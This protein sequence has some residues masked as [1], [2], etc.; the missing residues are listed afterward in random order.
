[1]T[2]SR[3]KP[4]VALLI[5]PLSFGRLLYRRNYTETLTRALGGGDV[6]AWTLQIVVSLIAAG[7]ITVLWRSRD[8]IKAAA[9][10]AGTL[11]ATPHLFAYDL[12]VLAVPLAFMFQLGRSRGF[13]QHELAGM[14]LACLL[15]LILPFVKAPVGFAAVF[16]VTALII[17]R[18]L[19]A[20]TVAISR[21]EYAS[22]GR[23]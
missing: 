8:E 16:V 3:S 9:I 4:R 17:R 19:E 11:L 15:I 5:F 12:V 1:M 22:I 6:L 23:E 10:V 18:A 13:L 7:A 20:R 21:S 2:T 14:G